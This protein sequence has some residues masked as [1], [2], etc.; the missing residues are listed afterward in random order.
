[1][2]NK[3]LIG[4][5]VVAVIGAYF[6]G[7]SVAETEGELEIERLKTERAAVV[8]A[9][10]DEVRKDY[11]ARMQSLMADVERIRNDNVERLRQLEQFRNAGRDLDTCR[12]E[13]S[14]LA[15]LAVRGESL[16]KRAD[17][18]FRAFEK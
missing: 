6:F 10:Q 7:Y 17:A 1:M 8:Q 16:L 13:R 18:Y 12:R 2:D 11:E 5:A 4:A 14:E 9:A 3:I 15:G